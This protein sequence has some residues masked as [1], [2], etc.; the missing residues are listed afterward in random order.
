MEKSG[1]EITIG[2]PVFNGEK[3]LDD[4]IS[5][6]L[7][8]TFKKFKL[9]ISDNASTDKTQVMCE[10]YATKDSR[11]LYIRH[12]K[13]KGPYWNFNYVLKQAETEFFVWNA[14]DDIMKPTFLEKNLDNLRTKKDIVGS[15]CKIEYYKAS[16]ENNEIRT[17]SFFSNLIKN[18][19]NFLHPFNVSSINGS[20]EER[21]RSYLK[22]MS[23]LIFYS[24]FR[25]DVVKKSIIDEYFIAHDFAVTLNILKFGNIDILGE[26][27]LLRGD[28]GISSKGMLTFIKL[29]S[30]M[31]GK[32]LP[33]YPFTSWCRKNL[34][35]KIFFIN[36]GYFIQ[37]NLEGVISLI[38]DLLR[39]I[40][41]KFN[42]K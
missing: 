30:S 3:Y 15:G 12:E 24:V 18:L 5:A 34:G 4:S 6:I 40:I 28:K 23:V 16:E 35:Y 14:V 37:L 25:T 10:S 22:K 26:T 7:N 29:N 27:L 13:N 9:I 39:C 19:R 17:N 36:F 32:F 38:L 8:Q 2:M 42:E 41:S 33:F 11:I 1:Y 31:L 20:Y 21:V